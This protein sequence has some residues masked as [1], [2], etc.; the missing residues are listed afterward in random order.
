M[1]RHDRGEDMRAN[2]HKRGI[3]MM[4]GGA[5]AFRRELAKPG[6][7]TARE[8]ADYMVRKLEMEL[9]DHIDDVREATER[10]RLRNDETSQAVL[11]FA[12]EL[13][14][15]YEHADGAAAAVLDKVVRRA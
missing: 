6:P 7:E 5:M 11:A 10:L 1:I 8:F 14:R 3:E 15:Q 13:L 9:A 4:I 2:S 12:E